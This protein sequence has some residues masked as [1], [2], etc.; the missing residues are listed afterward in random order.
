L[1]SDEIN[2]ADQGPLDRTPQLH[3]RRLV[4]T[5]MTAI[6]RIGVLGMALVALA[7]A[8]AAAAGRTNGSNGGGCP[9]SPA[10]VVAA[11]TQAHVYLGRQT[12][13]SDESHRPLGTIAIYRGCQLGGARSFLLGPAPSSC[14][15]SGCPTS[16]EH[17][18]LT[19]TVTAFQRST[20]SESSEGGSGEWLVIVRDL[21]TGRVLRSVPTGTSTDPKVVGVGP[22]TSIVLKKDGAVAWIVDTSREQ[23]RYEVH[24]ADRSGARLLASGS[25]IDPSSL[26]LGGSTLYWTQGGKASSAALR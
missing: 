6:S 16:L 14:G 26:A 25:D 19:G 15:S 24:A 13:F 3:A 17:L 4:S 21:R 5:S 18:T 11:D 20:T 23:N 1:G 2:V 7:V 12:Y 22:T 10:R 9:K 8:C